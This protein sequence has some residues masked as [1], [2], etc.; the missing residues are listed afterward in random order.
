VQIIT[1]TSCNIYPEVSGLTPDSATFSFGA[2]TAKISM[3]I[4]AMANF[5]SA[6]VEA[7]TAALM[8][9]IPIPEKNINN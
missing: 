5:V 2:V 3:S 7:A 8:P 9:E 6:L 1:G 4:Q